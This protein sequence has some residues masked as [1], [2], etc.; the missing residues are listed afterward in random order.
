MRI[1]RSTIDRVS[2]GKG[3]IKI[4]LA[5]KDGSKSLVLT[6]TNIFYLSTSP[7]NLLSLDLLNNAEIYHYN[8]NQIFCNQST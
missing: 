8:E 3:K 5:K 4:Q 1:G 7:S 6:L 2:P